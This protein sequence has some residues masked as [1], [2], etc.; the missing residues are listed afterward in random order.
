MI[1]ACRISALVHTTDSNRGLEVARENLLFLVSL[2]LTEMELILGRQETE[3][4]LLL[5]L[6][7]IDID[8]LQ[9]HE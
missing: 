4:L 1:A 8:G 9:V 3:L 6:Q 2:K 5:G 7:L